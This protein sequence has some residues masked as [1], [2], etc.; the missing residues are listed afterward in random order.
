MDSNANPSTF[1]ER[2]NTHAVQAPRYPPP[3]VLNVDELKIQFDAH[4]PCKVVQIFYSLIGIF[5]HMNGLEFE[6]D[7]LSLSERLKELD[8]R[9]SSMFP[10]LA[11]RKM[12]YI[13]WYFGSNGFNILRKVIGFNPNWFYK[14]EKNIKKVI[15]ILTFR[16]HGPKCDDYAMLLDP[17]AEPSSGKPSYYDYLVFHVINQVDFRITARYRPEIFNNC[18]SDLTDAAFRNCVFKNTI[19]SNLNTLSRAIK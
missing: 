7:D 13:Q 17:N 6:F 1:P 16:S 14:E 12:T 11:E 5:F 10:F 15:N 19:I 4:E 2:W 3:F 9:L 8:T 18:T